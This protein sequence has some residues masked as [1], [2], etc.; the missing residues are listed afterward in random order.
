M[1]ATGTQKAVLKRKTLPRKH[2]NLA[3][4][5]AGLLGILS[6]AGSAFRFGEIRRRQDTRPE[7]ETIPAPVQASGVLSVSLPKPASPDSAG[8][9]EADLGTVPDA[10][11]DEVTATAVPRE[12]PLPRGTPAAVPD[13]APQGGA[14]ARDAE[15]S[16]NRV[17]RLLSLLCPTEH[18]EQARAE[19]E[20]SR[21]R[22][23]VLKN[24]KKQNAEGIKQVLGGGAGKEKNAVGPKEATQ[25]GGSHD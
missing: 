23:Q 9:V 11:P 15:P 13:R 21:L 10:G 4:V 2:S 7:I 8:E 20:Q 22:L 19:M 25:E 1:T 24:I 6:V 12:D 3:I 14:S 17:D 16:S 5:L 18:R